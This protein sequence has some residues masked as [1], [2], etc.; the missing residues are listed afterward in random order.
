MKEKKTLMEMTP[1][2]LREEIGR[3]TTTLNRVHDKNRRRKRALKDINKFAII[4]NKT[5]T[6]LMLRN[7]FQAEM[8]E[9]FKA[10]V[11][12]AETL[13]RNETERLTRELKQ[14]AEYAHGR[15]MQA[16]SKGYTSPEPRLHMR[17]KDSAGEEVFSGTL[18]RVKEER[19]PGFWSRLFGRTARVGGN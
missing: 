2:E 4:S 17:M 15:E 13:L 11:D 3:L 18:H 1:Q 14:M 5:M 10:R 9:K 16:I 6:E 19:K 12:L 8:V 7:K